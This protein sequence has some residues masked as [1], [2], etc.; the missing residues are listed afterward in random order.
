MQSTISPQKLVKMS[1][2]TALLCVS[3]YISIPLPAGTHLTIMNF[4]VMLIILLFSSKESTLIISS[5]LVL[6]IAGVPVF[7]SGNAGLG[8]LFS[9]YGGY[10][11]A[12]LLVAI[13]IPSILPHDKKYHRAYYTT[14]SVFGAILVDIIG[15]LWLMLIGGFS[16]KTALITGFFPFIIIDMVK[17][18]VAAQVIPRIKNH[19]SSTPTF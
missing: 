17:A 14:V 2:F 19:I 7:V 13:L 5:W 12:F 15:T 18:V 4:I 9:Q 1:L 8:Y 11:I 6:G 3:A 10:H 16:M